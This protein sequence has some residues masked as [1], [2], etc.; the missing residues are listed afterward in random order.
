MSEEL[1]QRDLLKNPEKIGK[2]DF[3]NIGA[4]NIKSLIA[5][6]VI[7]NLAYPKEIDKRKPDGI[8][9]YKGDVIAIISNKLPK[10]L[11]K[12]KEITDWIDV[13]KALKS[14]LLIV[15]DVKTATF[16]VNALTGKHI[17]DEDGKDIKTLFDPSSD[18]IPKLIENILNSIDETNNQI[19]KP[20]L[21]D[22]TSLA[23]SVWQD[24]WMASGDDA[25][26]CLYTFVELFI[27]KYLSD[28]GILTGS[29]GF[30]ELLKRYEQDEADQV[31]DYYVR[32]IR[33]QIKSKFKEDKVDGTTIINGSTFINKKGE[34]VSGYSTVFKKVLE[35]FRDYEKK[36]GKFDHIHY[37]FKSK[38]FETFL[39]QSISK[40][41]WGQYF[42]PLKVVRAVVK[43]AKSDIKEGMT[44][45]DP[46]C[47]V[48]KFLLE[49]I[50]ENPHKYFKIEKGDVVNKINLIG[51]DK[52]FIDK[53][54]KTIILA[55]ANMLIYLSDLIREN[56][57][58]CT[59]F[60]QQFNNAFKLQT[61]TTLGT[62]VNPE[63]DKYDI[64]LTNPPYVTSGI[65]TL[66]D[67]IKT[68]G[69][70]YHYT[71]NSSGIEGLFMEWIIKA[72]RPEGKA[73]IIVPDG[74]LTRT[75][76]K[77]LREYI[78]NECFVE[79]IISLPK[80]TFFTTQ[81]KTAI[82]IISKKE[83]RNDVQTFP[84]F[85]YLVS[86][87]GE[88]LDINRFEIETNHLD[89]GAELFTQFK[90]SKSSFKPTDKRCKI[91]PIEKFTSETVWNIDAW[92]DEKEK[93]AL[94]IKE[95]TDKIK[96]KDYNTLT[97]NTIK[98]IEE[99]KNILIG[100]EKLVNEKTQNYKEVKLGDK[101]LFNLFIGKRVLKKDVR[102]TTGHI[103][104]YSANVFKPFAFLSKSNIDK[105]DHN[106]IMWGI[107]GD[108]EFN[109][110]SKNKP[111][112]TTDHC[113]T[114]QILSDD[115]NP[116]FLL[117]QLGQTKSS[118]EFDRTYRA[119][120]TNMKTFLVKIPVTKNGSFDVNA[121]N[122]IAEIFQKTEETKRIIEEQMNFLLK[123]QIVF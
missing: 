103:P 55:K 74:I 114:I 46:A 52:G 26:N 90:N 77:K 58:Y 66:K 32:F 1:L 5:N 97:A 85:T 91:Q 4:T 122:K 15:T 25:E 12:D 8:I 104:L 61:R 89:D 68:Q 86:E 98:I 49:V 88:T 62:L 102:Q 108:F 33:T 27:F 35:Q 19:I 53:E 93:I 34:P 41:N 116:Y 118:Y 78:T 99:Q 113:G 87:I 11:V 119:S 67:E 81:Q 76:D 18:K 59:E 64:I 82:L 10:K 31:L 17:K 95:E 117:Y 56:P 30:N 47:G 79:G 75:T 84:V 13:T 92:W 115:I 100:L 20:E 80:K 72:L 109:V 44:I 50:A 28:L 70:E 21:K 71:I 111:F 83:D 6:Q 120:L 7:K 23:K 69:L 40:K 51:Y 60:S 48:G 123:P 107:D 73:F 22:P 96:L 9:T 39:K 110:L 101:H 57:K 42:T 24:I 37:E 63:T 16:W 112:A 105:F 106:V 121:Q 45:G 3:Y 43:M 2:W 36:Y 54:Q 14:K 65:G 38:V 29:Y 94:G